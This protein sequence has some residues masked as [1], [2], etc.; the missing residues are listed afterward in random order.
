MKHAVNSIKNE[1]KSYFSKI[2]K[3][4][5]SNKIEKVD[6][7]EKIEENLSIYSLF[8]TDQET[9]DYEEKMSSLRIKAQEE[10]NKYAANSLTD[11]ESSKNS[12]V[13]FKIELMDP[14]MNRSGAK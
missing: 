3:E 7:S 4:K 8:N 11:L 12:E 6:T 9:S 2:N 10:L 1:V 5:N 14:S 13:A